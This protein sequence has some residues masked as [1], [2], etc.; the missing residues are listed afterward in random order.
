M[1]N[2]KEIADLVKEASRL[3]GL[4]ASEQNRVYGAPQSMIQGL[5][6]AE[7]REMKKRYHR[8]LRDNRPPPSSSRSERSGGADSSR[9]PNDSSY[10]NPLAH[11]T[12][13]LTVRDPIPPKEKP[14]ATTRRYPYSD[15]KPSYASSKPSYADPKPSY[16]DP[17]PSYDNPKPSS[18]A[19]P[20]TYSSRRD[21]QYSAHSAGREEPYYSASSRYKD[22]YDD[23]GRRPAYDDEAM[24]HLPPNPDWVSEPFGGRPDHRPEPKKAWGS[25]A[26]TQKHAAEGQ[27][28]S[29]TDSRNDTRGVSQYDRYAQGTSTSSRED[30]PYYSEV[31]SR[32]RNTTTTADRQSSPYYTSRQ[33]PGLSVAAPYASPKAAGARSARSSGVASV[34]SWNDEP[35]RVVRRT[36]RE[37]E[38]IRSSL[39]LKPNVAPPPKQKDIS[40]TQA[41]GKLVARPG[42][43]IQRVTRKHFGRGGGGSRVAAD[44]RRPAP[45]GLDAD[46]GSPYSRRRNHVAPSDSA[47]AATSGVAAATRRKHQQRDTASRLGFGGSGFGSSVAKRDG[48]SRRGEEDPQ[49]DGHRGGAYSSAGGGGYSGRMGHPQGIYGSERESVSRDGPG[50]R[51]VSSP[52]AQRQ[53]HTQAEP[54]RR[55]QYGVMDHKSGFIMLREE[56][57]EKLYSTLDIDQA[58]NLQESGLLEFDELGRLSVDPR[59]LRVLDDDFLDSLPQPRDARESRNESLGS[60]RAST[61]IRSRGGDPEPPLY[62]YQSSRGGVEGGGGYPVHDEPS[63]KDLSSRGRGEDRGGDAKPYPGD[64]RAGGAPHSSSPYRETTAGHPSA[65]SVEGRRMSNTRISQPPGGTSSIDIYGRGNG[66]PRAAWGGGGR[67]GKHHGGEADGGASGLDYKLLE[68]LGQAAY[69]QGMSLHSVFRKLASHGKTLSHEQFASRCRT[70]GVLVPPTQ[71]DIIYARFGTNGSMTFSQFVK[72]L[73]AATG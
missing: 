42:S 12:A 24:P 36:R 25:S 1:S 33:K 16:A 20:R 5:T 17:K 63:V 46:P 28:S 18:H 21:G 68:A 70:I 27:Y 4:L 71:V 41:A 22:L 14:P 11:R 61:N 40:S 13:K 47:Y 35:T 2:A 55:S 62:S 43:E 3:D 39:T 7:E 9:H 34:L 48:D 30:P 10:M 51:N 67:E 29:R 52:Y 57:A 53:R 37:H 65:R 56:V 60:P 38:P 66:R 15:P 64:H 31:S 58:K 23:G 59:V 26:S 73:G 19:D 32:L 72:L 6:G 45:F 8:A 50:G 49:K 54:Q 44:S 69:A